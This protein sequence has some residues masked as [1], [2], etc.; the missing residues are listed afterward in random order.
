MRREGHDANGLWVCGVSPEEDNDPDYPPLFNVDE[1]PVDH[2]AWEERVWP[3]RFP[4]GAWITIC[5]WLPESH[6]CMR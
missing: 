4:R 3:V 1:L 6:R 2:G 5:S